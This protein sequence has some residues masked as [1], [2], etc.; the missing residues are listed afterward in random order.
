MQLYEGMSYRNMYNTEEYNR[1]IERQKY[2][3]D[4]K[5]FSERESFELPEGYGLETAIYGD[6]EQV[7]K[8]QFVNKAALVKCAL[9]RSGETV[10]EWISTYSHPREFTEF[11]QHSNGHKY[12]PFHVDLYGISFLEL[13]TRKVFNYVPEG[14]QH[15]SEYTLGESFIIT[16]LHYN[17][18]TDLIAFGGCFW[19]GTNDVMVMK[20]SNP[21]DFEMKLVGI[22]DIIEPDWDIYD[23]IDFAKWQ[24]DK[25]VV[26][27]NGDRTKV[28]F[29]VE[30]AEIE[31]RLG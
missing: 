15:D 1:L 5:Y 16:D 13:D 31:K 11:I 8:N 7:G 3:L 24:G 6:T 26:I 28:E 21:L 10:H 25:L 14:Y 30:I 18:N 22:H 27:A 12:Y 17:I 23:N 20:L 19:A 9:K 4:E 2:V 29:A